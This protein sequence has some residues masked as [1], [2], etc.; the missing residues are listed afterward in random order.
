MRAALAFA[1]VLASPTA[2]AQGAAASSARAPAWLSVP[3][4]TGHL[5]ASDIGLVIN[6]A[7]PYSVAVGDY[8]IAARGLKPKQ[9]LRLQLST[10]AELGADE[11]KQLE[12]R[13]NDYFGSETQALALA[14]MRPYAVSCNSI[15]GALA[16]GLDESLCA[17]SC[18]PSK[19]SAY[20][21][22]PSTKPYAELKLRPSMLLAAR[23][24]EGA[25]AMIDRGVKSDRTLG[26][27]GVP[28]VQAY[29]L[30]TSDRARSVRTAF[31]PPGGLLQQQNID[32]HV[33]SSDALD[34]AQRVLLYQTGA[35]RVPKLDTIGWVPGALADHL[36]SFGGRLDDS[37]D[38]MSVLDWIASGATATYG[39]ASEPCA[40]PQK[41]PHPQ[42]LL[43]YYV[44]GSTAIEA[45]WKSVAWPQQ[46]V[47]VGEPLAAP[48]SR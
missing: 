21:N 37:G 7:D 36:T 12:S 48:F 43:L 5:S 1:M 4:V 9:V 11:F 45:Y 26:Y 22:S 46:G 6:T 15:T 29:Y 23:D 18:A 3:R 16:L 42:L 14:W 28:P 40:H 30:N 24:V 31:F 44:Q 10:A 35:V 38:Q 39:S 20:F 32:V 17:R 41:F 8:Y 27:R 34:G 2:V 13:I 33:E 19:R 25:K 47:F